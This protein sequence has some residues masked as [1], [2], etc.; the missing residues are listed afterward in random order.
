VLEDVLRCFV[1]TNQT[2]WDVFLPMAE[3]AMNNAPNAATGQSPF[4]LNYGVNPRH[5]AVMQL[6]SDSAAGRPATTS[7]ERRQQ[8]AALMAMR[9]TVRHAPDVP[10]ASQFSAD[11]RAAVQHTQLLLEAARQRM[12]QVADRKR[13]VAVEYKVG[14]QV[15]LS[16]KNIHLLTTGT[17]KLLPR[18]VGPFP[19]AAVINPVAYKLELP[20]TMRIHPVFHVSLL[21]RFRPRPG[22]S[23]HPRPLVVEDQEEYEVEAL[24]GMREKVISTKRTKHG[25][26]RRVKTQFLVK[27]AGYGHEHNEWTDEEELT[28]NCARLIRDFRSQQRRTR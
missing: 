5:P 9:V 10:A 4:V 1:D 7:R 2:N 19:V 8:A 27:W 22:Q 6:L 28:R 11:M 23:I 24:L 12:R 17:R 14:D 25:I 20:P 3:F 16:T 26:H 13:S 21:R 18:F 15:M